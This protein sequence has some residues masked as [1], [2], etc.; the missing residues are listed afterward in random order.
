MLRQTCL[1]YAKVPPVLQELKKQ[2]KQLL[3]RRM[4]F[5][6]EVTVFYL[7]EGVSRRDADE[8]GRLR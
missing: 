5:L 3:S 4:V 8:D 7:V 1:I 2:E 6:N